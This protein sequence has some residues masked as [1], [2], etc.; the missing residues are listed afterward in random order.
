MSDKK[1]NDLQRIP[2]NINEIHLK[3]L[4]LGYENGDN[5]KLFSAIGYCGRN[6]IIMPEWLVQS[7][8]D[9]WY[10]WIGYKVKTLDEAFG[11]EWPKRKSLAAARKKR[12]KRFE[13]YN[14]IKAFHEEGET[15][16]G[17]LF[18]K[19]GHD[20]CLG[21]TLAAEYYYSVKN[22]GVPHSVKVL[23]EP[24]VIKDFREK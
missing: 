24:F 23:L 11:L 18:E 21:K 6:K 8:H 9:S 3:E 10:E 17:E 2:D 1:T 5:A 15:I 19:V 4:R 7:F 12:N 16:D 20:L 22:I 13:V 14:R